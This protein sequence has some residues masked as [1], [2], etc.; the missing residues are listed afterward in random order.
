MSLQV[1]KSSDNRRVTMTIGQRFDF[2][3]HREFRDAYSKEPEDVEYIINMGSTEYMDSSALGMLL[4]LR[5]H[6]GEKPG[7]IKL[8][9][10][11]PSIRQILDISNFTK[12]FVVE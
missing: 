2:S 11:Q 4:V 12:L 6:T 7:K 5:E 9:G 3:L 8:T 1:S 10:C